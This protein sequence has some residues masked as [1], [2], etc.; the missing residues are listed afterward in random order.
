MRDELYVLIGIINYMIA[1]S[2]LLIANYPAVYRRA[3][4]RNPVWDSYFI[5]GE[6]QFDS[7]ILAGLWPV[8]YLAFYGWPWLRRMFARLT[9]V[10][11]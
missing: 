3:K 1:G 6:A 11:E 9:E 7:A 5:K 2:T 8:S 10:D 4:A